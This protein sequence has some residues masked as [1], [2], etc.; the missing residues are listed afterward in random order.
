[1]TTR[2]VPTAPSAA[3]PSAAPNAEPPR[4]ELS[5]FSTAPQHVRNDTGLPAR[6]SVAQGSNLRAVSMISEIW[7]AFEQKTYMAPV[8]I[9]DPVVDGVL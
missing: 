3:I 5:R 6:K 9:S 7:T 1:M 4:L 8:S 2:S